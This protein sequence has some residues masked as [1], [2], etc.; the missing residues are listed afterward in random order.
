MRP[1]DGLG[2]VSVR[3]QVAGCLRRMDPGL[4]S[5]ACPLHHIRI[6]IRI[7]I[8][9]RIAALGSATRHARFTRLPFPSICTPTPPS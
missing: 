2:P 3:G 9:T 8:R 5:R 6:R 4:Q 1:V 7:R